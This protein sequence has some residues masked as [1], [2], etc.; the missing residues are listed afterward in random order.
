MCD[1]HIYFDLAVFA[2]TIFLR[3]TDL[4][5]K[6]ERERGSFIQVRVMEVNM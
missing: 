1:G 3:D 2:R 4:K 5:K 6:K